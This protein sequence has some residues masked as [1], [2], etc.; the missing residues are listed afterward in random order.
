[1]LSLLAKSYNILPNMKNGITF[2]QEKYSTRT[3]EG[4]HN[5]A[6]LQRDK[7][8]ITYYRVKPGC[9]KPVSSTL[10]Y[11]MLSDVL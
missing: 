11:C 5:I 7:I 10:E 9:Y 4:T 1:M 3:L 2:I 8:R 6:D